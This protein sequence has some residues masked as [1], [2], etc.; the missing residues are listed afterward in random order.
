[1]KSNSKSTAVQGL[2]AVRCDQNNFLGPP[3]NLPLFFSLLFDCMIRIADNVITGADRRLMLYFYYSP[4]SGK[5]IVRRFT[6]L[7]GQRVKKDPAFKGFRESGNRMKEASPI[8]AALYKMVPAEVKQYSLYRI[9]TGV[10]LKMLKQGL[11]KTIITKTLKQ[12]YIDPLFQAPATEL[13]PIERKRRENRDNVVGI[14]DITK[15]FPVKSNG[16]SRIR[17]WRRHYTERLISNLPGFGGSLQQTATNILKKETMLLSGKETIH[18]SEKETTPISEQIT[19]HSNK[20][21]SITSHEQ[22]APRKQTS[23]FTTRYPE[24]M[25][26][27]RLRECKKLRLY[28]RSSHFPGV[29][30]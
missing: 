23:K 15:H 14:S 29:S 24:L 19:P 8:A 20:A 26:R 25:Y 18:L 12:K 22:T 1:M 16:K 2:C 4:V 6:S 17:R 10:A 5:N 28:I 30:H 9:L 27:G 7:T 21:V 11:N 3:H 13:V